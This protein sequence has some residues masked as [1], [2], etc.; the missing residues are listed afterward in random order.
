MSLFL[1]V[2]CFVPKMGHFQ[3]T[4]LCCKSIAAKVK[5]KKDIALGNVP[6][7]EGEGVKME[8]MIL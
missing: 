7:D 1:F 8:K 3:L 6:E 4:Q 2:E 5:Y